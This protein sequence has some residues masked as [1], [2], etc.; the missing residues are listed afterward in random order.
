MS[1]KRIGIALI[2]I[3]FL[4]TT[5]W[6]APEPAHACSCMRPDVEASLESSSEVFLGS[7]VAIEEVYDPHESPGTIGRRNVV[8]FEVER[9]YKHKVPSQMIVYAG[10][11]EASCGYDFAMGKQYLVY[12]NTMY[13]NELHTSFCSRTQ[14]ANI[15]GDDLAKLGEGFQPTETVDLRSQLE[16]NWLDTVQYHVERIIKIWVLPEAIMLS[17]IAISLL[18]IMLGLGFYLRTS[19]VL[20]RLIQ[21]VGGFAAIAAVSSSLIIIFLNPF[22]DTVTTTEFILVISMMLLPA[23]LALLSLWRRSATWMFIA[24]LLSLPLGLLIVTGGSRYSIATIPVFLYFICGVWMLMMKRAQRLKVE[25]T[26]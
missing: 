8:L 19:T 26:E 6:F 11:D 2:L 24:F 10:F 12:G 21:W 23:C 3:G 22:V 5:G 25:V 16:Q 9:S 4:S 7:V 20:L 15:A 17:I 13:E 1:M 18:I 14:P